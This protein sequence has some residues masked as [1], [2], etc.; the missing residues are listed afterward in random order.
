MK[1]AAIFSRNSRSGFQDRSRR[2]CFL[3]LRVLR[4]AVGSRR[5]CRRVVVVAA[6]CVVA[7]FVV[8]AGVVVAVAVV[9][10]AV[11]RVI[12]VGA[13]RPRT[14]QFNEQDDVFQRS[15]RTDRTHQRHVKPT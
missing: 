10:V 2:L 3:L 9:V 14:Q 1:G 7:V 6:L 4:V 8:V 11:A 13:S 5:P 12:A 15:A